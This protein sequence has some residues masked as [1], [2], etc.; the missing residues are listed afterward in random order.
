MATAEVFHAGP[1]DGNPEPAGSHTG[2]MDAE[3]VAQVFDLGPPTGPLVEAARG[4]GGQN[5]VHRLVTRRA[6]PGPSRRCTRELDDL[7][8]ERFEIE[9]AAFDGG[10]ARC[11]DR[12]RVVTGRPR[13]RS[14]RPS[15]GA[16]PGRRARSRPTRTPPCRKRAAWAGSSPGCTAS[17]WCG[18]HAP[19]SWRRP[20][21]RRTG[22]PS[23]GS[24]RHAGR[25]GRQPPREHLDELEHLSDV[26][27]PLTAGLGGQL[28]RVGSHRDLNAHNVLFGRR[29]AV[30]RSTGTPRSDGAPAAE[31]AIYARLWAARGSGHL[32]PETP[33]MPSSRATEPRVAR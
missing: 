5:V 11:P 33:P 14:T 28:A 15:S 8:V 7:A 26:A 29:I 12:C 32:R 25:R 16:T 2:R 10:R 20:R 17:R 22:P 3:E 4:W 6:A 24:A 30:A 27:P 31:R 18:R 19:T 21:T 1:R 9:Q 23:P 13:P